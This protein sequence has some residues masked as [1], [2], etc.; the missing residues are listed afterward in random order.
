MAPGGDGL[1]RWQPGTGIRGARLPLAALSAIPRPQIILNKPNSLPG[2]TPWL[3]TD[4]PQPSPRAAGCPCRA[5]S[6]SLILC[7]PRAAGCPRRA[8]SASLILCLPRAAGCPRRAF[9]ASFVFM[10]CGGNPADGATYWPGQTGQRVQQKEAD[11]EGSTSSTVR[12]Q[13]TSRP[14][15]SAT[16][17]TCPRGSCP[18]SRERDATRTG[19]PAGT[20]RSRGRR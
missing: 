4:C 15:G 14:G 9:C 5:F 2:T 8:F 3:P 19:R 16:G 12:R 11:R 6:A 1:P 18:W 7:L 13:A 17:R 20:S 10:P